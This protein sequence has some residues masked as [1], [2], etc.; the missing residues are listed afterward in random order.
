MIL[1][2]ADEE[3]A[4]SGVGAMDSLHIAAAFLLHADEFVTSEKPGK[5]IYRTSLV[6]VIYLFR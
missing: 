3:S 1:R 2:H 6:K 5:S 4:K